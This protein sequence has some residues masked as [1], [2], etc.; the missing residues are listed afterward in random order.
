VVA[1]L[2]GERFIGMRTPAWHALG[3][4]LPAD[5]QV[6]AVEAFQMAKLNFKYAV[7]PIG[8][9]LPD[10][11]FTSIGTDKAIYRE[12]T[13]DSPEWKSLGIVSKDFSVLQND[14]LAR[15]IDAIAEKTG[16]KFETAGALGS[17]ETI[18]VCLKT[19]THSI[20]G[21]EVD[22][23]FLVSDGKAGNR[24]LK[25]SV[26]PVRVVCQNT[27]IMSDTSSNL[28]ITVPHSNGV[29]LEYRFWLNMIS[30]LEHSQ[31]VVFADLR[32]LADRRITDDIAKRI[33]LDA[34]PEPVQNQ[35]VKL[36]KSIGTMS[37]EDSVREEATG[38]LS[39]AVMAYD[40]NLA[41]SIKWREGAYTLYQ[42]FN[43]GDE[44]GG[45]MSPAALKALQ[46]TAYA[47]LQ[48]VTELC[49][50]GG[51]NRESASSSSLF[52]A[53][54]AQKTRAWESCL[55]ILQPSLN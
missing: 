55:K 37:I 31:E 53:R 14:D 40:Y 44:Q 42:R 21:D 36:A 18:F 22:S 17:G 1:D 52:G 9:T 10:G 4:T 12:P 24:S 6:T 54:A 7:L 39:N 3:I 27:L 48:A 29:E 28:S 16:W 50:F 43:E 26:T 2:F 8:V 49:D 46:G 13:F 51:M 38:A 15:G 20:S 41:Q 47:A 5:Q 30:Q 34:F 45:Q 32:R 33:F 35:R 25:I 19:G 11:T 23:Y